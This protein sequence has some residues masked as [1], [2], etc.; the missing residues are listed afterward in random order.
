[1]QNL[2]H[3]GLYSRVL[4]S[5][6]FH[7]PL[8]EINRISP[9]YPTNLFPP[10]FTASMVVNRWIS[11]FTNLTFYSMCLFPL[12][13]FPWLGVLVPLC[14]IN[15]ILNIAVYTQTIWL[16]DAVQKIYASLNETPR[17]HPP[18]SRRELEQEFTRL[19]IPQLTIPHQRRKM[20]KA[21]ICL[22]FGGG[23]V[24][25]TYVVLASTLSGEAA[26]KFQILFPI[27]IDRYFRMWV[28]YHVHKFETMRDR[29][30]E[31]FGI[32]LIVAAERET[33]MKFEATGT[34]AAIVP[35][36]PES[37]SRPGVIAVTRAM[38]P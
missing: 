23:I 16:Q 10:A 15:M 9:K 35:P 21:D 28:W 26:T 8:L 34:T 27:L 20:T 1:M 13:S 18:R 7:T 4:D 30:Y 25:A 33:E 36:L 38:S 12:F 11:G 17:Y 31:A 2:P 37:V 14:I 24:L 22:T 3:Q 29:W 6:F 19:I 5:I 32:N